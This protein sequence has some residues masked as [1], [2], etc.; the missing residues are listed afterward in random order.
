[1]NFL[2]YRTLLHLVFDHKKS[3]G[4]DGDTVKCRSQ[5][6]MTHKFG[7]V[8]SFVSGVEIEKKS[9][10]KKWDKLQRSKAFAQ[11]VR[12]VLSEYYFYRNKKTVRFLRFLLEI[13]S[14]IFQM[15]NYFFHNRTI[16]ISER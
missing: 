7:R 13:F 8:I 15:Q 3:F 5:E 6:L 14:L 1:M 4:F 12:R 2:K 16:K 9:W 11:D 10:T